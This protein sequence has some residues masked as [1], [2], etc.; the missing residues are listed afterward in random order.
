MVPEIT[1]EQR[2]AALEKAKEARRA[3]HSIRAALKAGTLDPVRA[4]GMEDARRMKVRVFLA[5]LPGVGGAT[6]DEALRVLGI[7]PSR[8]IGGLGCRQVERLTDWIVNREH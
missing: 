8:R 7:A 4:I 2:L 1:D 3:R 5:S 6:A